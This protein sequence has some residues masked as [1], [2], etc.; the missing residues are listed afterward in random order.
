MRARGS[1]DLA[2]RVDNQI[3]APGLE[4]T[5]SGR[6]PPSVSAQLWFHLP[7]NSHLC[8]LL[9]QRVDAARVVIELH[10]RAFLSMVCSS[11]MNTVFA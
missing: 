3:R 11:P 6:L 4:R 7:A 1:T 10:P 5:Q 2:R 9:T 8:M